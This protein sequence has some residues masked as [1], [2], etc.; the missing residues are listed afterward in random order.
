ME[1]EEQHENR[2]V[3]AMRIV[4]LSYVNVSGETDPVQWLKKIRF[5]TGIPEQMSS[6]HDV[7]SIHCIGDF[8]GVQYQNVSYHFFRLDG[9]RRIYPSKVHSHVASLKPD[10][11]VVHGLHFPWQVLLLKKQL[12]GAVKIF[13]QHHAEKPFSDF[14]KLFQK[15]V[16]EFV[17]GYFFTAKGLA[18]SWIESGIIS[19][20]EKI[21]EVMEGSTSFLP[22]DRNAAKKQIGISGKRLYL[23][24][25]RLDFNKDPETLIKSFIPF[26]KA[27]P[28]VALCIIHKDD[29]LLPEVEK[30]LSG[31]H[32]NIKLVGKVDHEKMDHWYNAADFIISTSHYEGSGLSVCEAMA[33]GCIPILSD[34]PSF[35]MMTANNSV[36]IIFSPGNI[37]SLTKALHQ[38][39]NFDVERER[40][41]V[42]LQFRKNLSF[43]GIAKKMIDAF[44]SAT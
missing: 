34:I 10:I 39:N 13:I 3:I 37:E 29:D 33:C 6:D 36:G 14:R 30:L 35:R 5:Y 28:Q 7:H 41:K 26:A 42:L 20:S 19:S 15:R 18:A 38:S 1:V 2:D 44:K 8:G 43:E 25:G 22:A 11:I 23:W 40:E 31:G 16:D 24:V 12:S 27:N 9:W 4:H 21:I 17:S 32:E